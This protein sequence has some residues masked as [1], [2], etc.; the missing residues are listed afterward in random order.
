MKTKKTMSK[1]IAGA[2]LALA[3]IA[4]SYGQNNLGSTCGCPPVNSR[5][6]VTMSAL[7]GF[8]TVANAFGGELTLGA[9]LSCTAN[10]LIDQK[11]YV[12]SG[13]ILQIAPGTVLKGAFSFSTAAASAIIVERGA[14]ILAEGT[15]D[16]PIVFT[17]AADP[18]DGTYPISN[19]GQWGGV[20]LLGR[21]SN[22][23][24]YSLNG[25]FASGTGNGRLS[26][27]DGLG[28]IEGF[29]TSVQQDRFGAMLNNNNP[30]AGES[31]GTFNDNDNSGVMK[32]VS[33][34]HSGA[35]LSVG[36]EINGLTLGSVGRGTT[37]DY[38]EI[39]SCADDNI[40]FF[41]GTVNIKHATVL[42]GGDDMFDYDLGWTGKAQFLFG[43]KGDQTFSV[44][45]DNGFEM[46]GDDQKSCTTP[47]SHPVIYN[48]T[49]IGNTKSAGTSD[50][51]GLCGM[52]AKELTEGEIYNSIIANF[53][54]G[55]NLV[56]SLG[57][58]TTNCAIETFTNWSTATG[59]ANRPL[60]IV[61]NTFVGVTNP[62]TTGAGNGTVIGTP[63]TSG[64]NFTQFT[65]TDMNSIVVG[66]T[67]PGF[68][69]NFSVT[70]ATNFF[71]VRN[72]V[73]PNPALSVVGCPTAPNDGF[74][75][76]APY[77]GAF[78]SSGSTWISDWS[79]SAV[80]GT[81]QGAAFCATDLNK[82]GLTDINDFL[83]FSSSFGQSCQ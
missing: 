82:D 7:P 13:Q 3:A 22:N 53:R 4:P 36:N 9:V 19:T 69:Y 80:I 62:L 83:Q 79:Y 23:L 73:V 8:S 46:D 30:V 65:T 16:C 31:V 54:N 21:A 20:V 15:K 74:F 28:V 78:A 63:I 49:F 14:Q 24:V 41:G 72:D 17:A 40:E 52:Q 26:V 10:Y 39:V 38:I 58:R 77:R 37:L 35:I 81:T 60:K 66:N 76:F 57:T 18:V 6:T 12:A 29:A 75:A 70:P 42:F 67:L 56:T 47:R 32:Y 51:S 27:A 34:R 43:M 25:P 59:G 33:I 61:C 71:S 44:D 64:A 48:A 5:P 1:L 55:L 68:S 2:A 50:N 11:I 45:S